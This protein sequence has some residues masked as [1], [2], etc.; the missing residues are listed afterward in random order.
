MCI[1]LWN[2]KQKQVFYQPKGIKRQHRFLDRHSVSCCR[3]LLFKKQIERNVFCFNKYSTASS[4]KSFGSY[5]A[6]EKNALLIYMLH[7]VAWL[8]KWCLTFKYKTRN[9]AFI[10]WSIIGISTQTFNAE[11]DTK[12]YNWKYYG[13][14]LFEYLH[15]N[16]CIH[17][18][19]RNI[20]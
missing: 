11:Y 5:K 18:C 14:E 16:I 7:I 9:I 6:Q 12:C 1:C 13:A 3:N 4:I 15:I 8:K 19:S 20:Y 10:D 17:V 2:K